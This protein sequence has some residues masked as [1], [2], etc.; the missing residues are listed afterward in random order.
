MS[1]S[2]TIEPDREAPR[3]ARKPRSAKVRT[4]G[5]PPD[6]GEAREDT[7][8]PPAPVRERPTLPSLGKAV[9]ACRACDLYRH[10]TQPV[11]GAGEKNAGLMLVG[12]QPGN[13]EDL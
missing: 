11:F 7:G 12:E 2:T 6:R 9:T 13:D 3:P 4:D 1:T 8:H 10:A 5:G